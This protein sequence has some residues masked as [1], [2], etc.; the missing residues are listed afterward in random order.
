[1]VCKQHCHPEVFDFSKVCRM[2]RGIVQ[3][4]KHLVWQLILLTLTKQSRAKIVCV[5]IQEDFLCNPSPLVPFLPIKPGLVNTKNEIRRTITLLYNGLKLC[6][7]PSHCTLRHILRDLNCMNKPLLPKH[8]L[9]LP[10]YSLRFSKTDFALSLITALVN[11][12]L[13][14]FKS[15]THNDNNFSIFF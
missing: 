6:R 4:K 12:M 7:P 14:C 8:Y 9:S 15:F 11:K 10:S 2:A 3:E 5:P 1:M 13:L